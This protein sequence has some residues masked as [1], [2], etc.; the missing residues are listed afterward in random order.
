ME[1]EAE[2]RPLS[3]I[4]LVVEAA[5]NKQL[6]LD[7]FIAWNKPEVQKESLGGLRGLF[8]PRSVGGLGLNPKG[9]V[10]RV[11]SS[12]R[13]LAT[14][15]SREIL[16][17]GSTQTSNIVATRTYGRR[18]IDI[19]LHHINY[20]GE[21]NC[22]YPKLY[23]D[24]KNSAPPVSSEILLEIEGDPLKK[25][26]GLTRRQHRLLSKLDPALGSLRVGITQIAVNR[27][28]PRCLCVTSDDYMYRDDSQNG[29]GQ[30][31]DSIVPYQALDPSWIPGRSTDCTAL[32]HN[33]VQS[34]VETY[35]DGVTQAT[36]NRLD[37]EI[38][39][40][41]YSRTDRDCETRYSLTIQ[42]VT[43]HGL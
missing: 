7:R 10:V 38:S 21:L 30:I 31:P 37:S 43:E 17:L 2:D 3:T 34:P 11:S 15:Y 24:A 5:W 16:S 23:I 32:K 33:D 1:D 19:P 6:A 20:R 8:L 29:V 14:L 18:P 13:K 27:E 39:E 40:S 28:M 26:K 35:H 36:R 25:F 42:G 41:E 22:S 12:Q 9:L 4:E